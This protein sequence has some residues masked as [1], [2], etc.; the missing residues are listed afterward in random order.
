MLNFKFYLFF[1]VL[2]SVDVFETCEPLSP[3]H[4]GTQIVCLSASSGLRYGLQPSKTHRRG[5]FG[6]GR[7]RRDLTLQ[8]LSD[9]R[10]RRVWYTAGSG[11]I[12]IYISGNVIRAV[13]Q[14][15][16]V[17]VKGGVYFNSARFPEHFHECI[18]AVVS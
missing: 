9:M 10:Y 7:D 17:G 2:S 12:E 14:L 3:K 18:V 11:L 15:C 4:N 13:T 6:M 1:Q 5:C 8:K 16:F